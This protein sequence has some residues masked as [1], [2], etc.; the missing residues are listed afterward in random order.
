MKL[1]DRQE[2]VG[3]CLRYRIQKQQEEVRLGQV[4]VGLAETVQGLALKKCSASGSLGR[5]RMKKM[6]NTGESRRYLTGEQGEK[7]GKKQ[8]NRG[9]KTKK[10]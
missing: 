4:R 2:P 9:K 5:R 8:E 10:K 7:Q 3:A 1:G 6:E